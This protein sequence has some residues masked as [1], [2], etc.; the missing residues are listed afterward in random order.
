[1]FKNY[2]DWLKSGTF[3]TIIVGIIGCVLAVYLY[4]L[5]NKER[6][7]VYAVKKAPSL[8]FDKDNSS[9][10]IKLLS[11]DS[12]VVNQN[13]YV[14][15]LA[16]WNNG[17]LPIEKVDVRKDFKIEVPNGVQILDYKIVQ[18]THPGISK[19]RIV[20][21][22]GQLNI[23]WEYFDPEFGLEMQLMYSGEAD[24][25]IK[26]S[27]YVLGT[28]MK[29][30]EQRNTF[31]SRKNRIWFKGLAVLYLALIVAIFYTLRAK[32]K[33]VKLDRFGYVLL[34]FLGLILVLMI[35]ILLYDSMGYNL[36]L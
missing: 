29:K 20:P 36:P 33:N 26:I 35:I 16:I 24:D 17:E 11:S 30:V 4:K 21:D 32:S 22:D 12:I 6:E 5:S 2:K 7:P 13:V 18:E 8:I 9:P 23:D 25:E 34:I 3:W 28:E 19:F 27:G 1:M 15:S 31:L 10:K 14:T